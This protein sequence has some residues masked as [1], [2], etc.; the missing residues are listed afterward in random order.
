MVLS[1]KIPR[2]F[3]ILLHI[4]EVLMNQYKLELDF[5]TNFDTKRHKCF[6]N[7]K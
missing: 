2:K 7:F 6:W 1:Y 5:L 3:L 4:I